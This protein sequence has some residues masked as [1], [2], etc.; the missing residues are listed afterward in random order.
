MKIAYTS[1]IHAD[2]YNSNVSNPLKT[3]KVV[4]HYI[5]KGENPDILIIAGDISHYNT[6]TLNMCQYLNSKG[7]KVIL[8]SGNHEFYNVSKNQKHKYT[9]LYDKFNELKELLKPL[10]DTY[11]LDGNTITLNDIKFGGAMSWYDCSYYYK[12]AQGMYQGDVS[13]HWKNYSNDARLIPE[14][15]YPTMLYNKEIIKVK[16]VLNEHPDIMISHVC[17]ISE[18]ISFN[19]K[20]KMDKSSGYY[21]F[22]GL[23][24]IDPVDNLKP[25]KFWIHGHIHDSHEFEIYETKHLRNPLG[26]PNETS[27]FELKYIT[28]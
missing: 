22:N 27:N 17:P 28:F 9:K 4:E 18:S 23:H 24:L 5:L 13:N 14:L 8:V 25:P 12:I 2:F 6:Q 3:E 7:I 1:D 21:C 11:F 26:Y 15:D 16:N 19:G 10:E 20:H